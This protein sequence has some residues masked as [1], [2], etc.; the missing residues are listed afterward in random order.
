MQDNPQWPSGVG[1]CGLGRGIMAKSVLRRAWPEGHVPLLSVA[2]TPYE[3]G[4]QLGYA[5]KEAFY[6]VA[7]NWPPNTRPWWMD[8]RYARLISRHAPHL[9]D[10]YRGMA[11]GAGVPEKR[12]S[13]PAPGG[14]PSLAEEPGGC[15]SF[16]V[17]PTTTLDGIPISGQTKDTGSQQ[18]F[19]F[20]VLR[21]QLRGAPSA[22]TLTYPGLLFGH[23]F[24]A[25]GCSLFRNSLFAGSAEKGLPAHVWGLLALHCTT[26]EAA[27]EIA[28]RYGIQGGGHYT[29][30]DA[31]GGIVGVEWGQGGVAILRPK[32]GI[33]THANAVVSGA[34]L[35]RY[36]KG[37]SWGPL[38]SL[39]R[40]TRLRQR[41]EADR[42][43]LTAQLAFMALCDHV[44]YPRSICRHESLD[45]LTTA[46][47]VVEP[48]RGLLHATRGAPC[49]NWPKTYAL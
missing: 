23:G 7:R 35:R 11:K 22:L 25:G 18:Q 5:W 16:A 42:G 48:T 19:R 34:R 37:G 46:A 45:A 33:Y 13:D 41:L 8:R 27:G 30:A 31:K 32:R 47:V 36:E 1:R 39:Q 14:T 9:P 24:V 6:H 26:A 10:L 15:T 4:V 21:L 40:Q 44:R 29:I 28:L 43:R 38:N 49:M 2:G 20:V 3:A 12:L 17:H